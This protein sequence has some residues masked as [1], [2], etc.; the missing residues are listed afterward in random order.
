MLEVKR[1][2]E[3]NNNVVIFGIPESEQWVDEV[4]NVFSDLCVEKPSREKLLNVYKAQRIG[5]EVNDKI[6][7]IKL[8]LNAETKKNVMTRKKLLS[9]YDK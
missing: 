2:V 3:I 6:R 8:K 9:E 7:P 1:R 5:N 4:S